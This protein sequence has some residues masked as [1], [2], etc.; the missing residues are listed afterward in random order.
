MERYVFVRGS[1]LQMSVFPELIS[2]FNK[3]YSKSQYFYFRN[4]KTDFKLFMKYKAPRI[5]KKIENMSQEGFTQSDFK[6]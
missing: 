4:W 6:T 2:R 1:N 3:S 5:A